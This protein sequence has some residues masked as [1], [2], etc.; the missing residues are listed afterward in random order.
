MS[1]FLNLFYSPNLFSI[2]ILFSFTYVLV[3]LVLLLL[4]KDFSSQLG[5]G[6]P[7]PLTL[8]FY[9]AI[10]VAPIPPKLQ[11]DL[12]IYLSQLKVNNVE[13][14]GMLNTI[15]YS[16]DKNN[17]FIRGVDYQN[18]IERY[19]EDIDDHLRKKG[20]FSI[21]LPDRALKFTNESICD[22]AIEYNRIKNNQIES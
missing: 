4:K 11:N 18:I 20:T 5:I 6:L 22:S 17:G 12:K 3:L 21:S 8:V 9:L 7:I 14:N 1:G 10:L 19:S 13:T 15:L 2:L 16:C